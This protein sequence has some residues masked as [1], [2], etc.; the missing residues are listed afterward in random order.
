MK[1]LAPL[2]MV[3]SVLAAFCSII[4]RHRIDEVRWL[5][6]GLS[7][8]FGTGGTY[9][10]LVDRLESGLLGVLLIGDLDS[11]DLASCPWP[12]KASLLCLP[13]LTL[14]RTEWL[15]WR[16]DGSTEALPPPPSSSDEDDSSRKLSTCRS[17][18]RCE[19]FLVDVGGKPLAL[20]LLR[21]FQEVFGGDDTGISELLGGESRR[22]LNLRS[23]GTVLWLL[24]LKELF[25]DVT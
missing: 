6:L 11:M 9:S 13:F 15:P 2:S 24:L 10:E 8:I 3:L 4:S 1:E 21:I 5:G 20:E 19:P 18:P 17:M 23:D 7:G 25:L 22:K 14:V 16:S 12:S